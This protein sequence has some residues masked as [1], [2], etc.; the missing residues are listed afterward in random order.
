MTE[1]AI[2]AAQRAFGMEETG[3]ADNAFQQKL[4]EGMAEKPTP[5]GQQSATAETGE[6]T[7]RK[8]VS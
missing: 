6:L 5:V 1:E 3:I 7:T 4:Y 2:K 8:P